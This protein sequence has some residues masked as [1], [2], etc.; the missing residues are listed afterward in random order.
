MPRVRRRILSNLQTPMMNSLSA[1]SIEDRLMVQANAEVTSSYLRMPSLRVQGPTSAAVRAL[2]DVTSSRENAIP[3]GLEGTQTLAVGEDAE[4]VEVEVPAA[5]YVEVEM[6]AAGTM[7]AAA[8]ELDATAPVTA[9]DSG[10]DD[11]SDSSGTTN[12]GGSD[13]ETA[14]AAA[15]SARKRVRTI[16]GAAM[17]AATEAAALASERAAKLRARIALR[18]DA[19]R[20][21]AKM[22]KEKGESHQS[23]AMR[24]ILKRWHKH[25]NMAAAVV[26]PKK[27]KVSGTVYC[28]SCAL[29]LYPYYGHTSIRF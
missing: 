19:D 1:V 12:S 8:A 25:N 27:R 20:L 24:R 16:A 3:V 17:D 13:D 18:V 10:R 11:G 28:A 21:L 15:S 29:R 6:P 14:A 23:Y 26:I 7:A 9:P 22:R 4:S 5:E 2:D